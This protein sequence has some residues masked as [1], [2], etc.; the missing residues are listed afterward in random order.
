MT[1]EVIE[2]DEWEAYGALET[3]HLDETRDALQGAS[4]MGTELP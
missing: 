1:N 2:G 3:Y 4:L